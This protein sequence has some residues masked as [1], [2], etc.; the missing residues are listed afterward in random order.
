[1]LAVAAFAAMATGISIRPDEVVWLARPTEVRSCYRRESVPAPPDANLTLRCRVTAQGRLAACRVAPPD[2][3]PDD[4]NCAL[5]VVH[6]MRM[7]LKTKS[8]RPVVGRM[9]SFPVRFRSQ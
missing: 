7:R 3:N 9:L 6:A 2:A 4:V 1:M 8:G 5:K